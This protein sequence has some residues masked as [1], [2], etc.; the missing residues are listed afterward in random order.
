MVLCSLRDAELAYLEKTYLCLGAQI[1]PE[2][3]DDFEH[4][5]R[6]K[7]SEC[8]LQNPLQLD[9]YTV[10]CSFFSTLQTHHEPLNSIHHYGDGQKTH[11]KNQSHFGLIL[12]TILKQI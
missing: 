12:F 1:D 6:L 7:L 3:W 4:S 8:D 2:C 10:T 9:I 5:L 11:K